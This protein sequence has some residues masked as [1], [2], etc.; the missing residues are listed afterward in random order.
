MGS[1][2]DH[3]H[4]TAGLT[5]YWIQGP[6]PD[7]N[8]ARSALDFWESRRACGRGSTTPGGRPVEQLRGA[9]RHHQADAGDDVPRP[10]G[11]YWPCS[12]ER[13]NG[14][15]D[16]VHI[17][18]WAKPWNVKGE[19]AVGDAPPSAL[20]ATFDGGF[21]QVG[22]VYTAQVSNT[23]GLASSSAPTSW[24]ATAAWSPYGTPTRIPISNGVPSF[25][26]VDG[27]S[28]AYFMAHF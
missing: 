22:C 11:Y 15:V 4:S 12:E 1:D 14:L 13:S 2:A 25:L 21:E 18:D 3:N 24:P 9:V 17:G 8:P 28:D 5:G 7:S 27:V 26:W 10:A 20:W 19:R 16:D 6:A 23:T